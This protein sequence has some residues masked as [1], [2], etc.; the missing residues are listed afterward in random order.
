MNL[1]IKCPNLLPEPRKAFFSSS[2]IN[3]DW[4]IS[5][6]FLEIGKTQQLL[7]FPRKFIKIIKFPQKPL[8]RNRFRIFA[9]FITSH[10]PQL[11]PLSKV[12]NS[13]IQFGW[14]AALSWKDVALKYENIFSTKYIRVR[15]EKLCWTL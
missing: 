1:F 2:L 14:M 5:W 6:E 11:R 4:R 3:F 8:N 15:S 12:M 9:W 13:A 10:S 7:S